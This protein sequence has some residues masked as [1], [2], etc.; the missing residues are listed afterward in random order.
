[1]EMTKERSAN[2]NANT[3]K[4]TSGCVKWFDSFLQI[5]IENA[6]IHL[7]DMSHTHTHAQ[8]LSGVC[9]NLTLY[10]FFRRRMSLALGLDFRIAL[11]K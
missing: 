9:Q 3:S 10:R 8:H 2:T 1:M 7:T 4:C 11:W 5:I 6:R